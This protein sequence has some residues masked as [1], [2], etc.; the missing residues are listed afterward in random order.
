[1]LIERDNGG[2]SSFVAK[3]E[4]AEFAFSLD[5]GSQTFSSDQLSDVQNIYQ[6]GFSAK[7]QDLFSDLGGFEAKVNIKSCKNGSVSLI[8]GIF[9]E[10]VIPVVISAAGAIVANEFLKRKAMREARIH[11]EEEFDSLIK[12]MRQIVDMYVVDTS[13]AHDENYTK[14][15][16]RH[17]RIPNS[18]HKVLKS[19]E[20]RAKDYDEVE[21]ILDNLIED[22][23]QNLKKT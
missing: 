17:V 2:S 12:N 4:V 8:S 11:N 21:K 13:Y 1:M 3:V 22:Y 6:E 18:K 9:I 7:L 10:V 20:F 23:R 14:V 16:R 5:F 19:Y 15:Y